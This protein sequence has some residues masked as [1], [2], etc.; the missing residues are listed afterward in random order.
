M[1][2]QGDGWQVS[3]AHAAGMGF[4]EQLHHSW[5]TCPT[6][7]HPEVEHPLESWVLRV[8]VGTHMGA[9]PLHPWSIFWWGC[10]A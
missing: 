4:K 10:F 6:C 9:A 7:P 1:A 5:E 8:E 2:R 3:P